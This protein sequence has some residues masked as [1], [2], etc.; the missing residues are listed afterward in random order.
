MVFFMV[1]VACIKAIN[2]G[3]MREELM[4]A[5]YQLALWSNPETGYTISRTR[6][7]DANRQLFI[8]RQFHLACNFL[9]S[10]IE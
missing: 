8:K 10:F 3:T 1:S 5:W 9:Q 7:L 6:C 4:L 2:L